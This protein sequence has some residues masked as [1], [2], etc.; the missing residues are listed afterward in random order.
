LRFVVLPGNG[1]RTIEQCR[2]Y[3]ESAIRVKG[4]VELWAMAGAS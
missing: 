2:G 1:F 3:T 4:G